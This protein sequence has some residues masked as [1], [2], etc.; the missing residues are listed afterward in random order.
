MAEQCTGFDAQVC[1]NCLMYPVCALNDQRYQAQTQALTS[2]SVEDLIKEVEMVN[3]HYSC[4]RQ[5]G[6]SR[7]E[8]LEVTMYTLFGVVPR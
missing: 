2:R 3:D 4:I 6:A 7:E 1:M 5:S 8:A